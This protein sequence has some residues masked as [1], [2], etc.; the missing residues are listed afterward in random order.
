MIA[1]W[2]R[3]IHHYFFPHE[4]NNF[5]AKTL[6]SSAIIFYITLLIIFQF[7]LT[8]LKQLDP[9][10][11]GYATDITMDKLLTLV[12]QKR[13]ESGLT[14]LNISSELSTAATQKASDMLSQDYW[15]HISPTG[16]TPWEF[17]NTSGYEYLYA[18]ENLARNFM[19]SEE[20]V[21]AWM[22]SPT[23]R[24]N[25]LKAEYTDIG[26]AVL[27]GKLK[28]EETTLVVQQFGTRVDK[29]V[30]SINKPSPTV[31]QTLSGDQTQVV[32][33]RQS[34]IPITA[35]KTFSIVI[36][37]FLLVILFVDSLYIWRNK[38][39]RVSGHSLA[40][41]IFLAALIGAMGA[42]GIGVIL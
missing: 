34:L 9:N 13:V 1:S 24:A 25:I 16:T 5:R 41:I 10:I 14:P 30:A 39:V 35:S 7:S 37:E 36:A 2:K 32:A 38:T 20:V 8:V 17:I 12:N 3:K 4:S 18:G 11:L 29:K 26:L 19:T 23:H 15:A 33:S 42:T 6:H 22:N 27:N 28:G 31:K 21:E 40:H